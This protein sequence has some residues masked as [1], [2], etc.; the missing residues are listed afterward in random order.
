MQRHV[1]IVALLGLVILI[2]L[3][4]AVFVRRYTSLDSSLKGT[5]P[6]GTPAARIATE[7]RAKLVSTFL[8]PGATVQVRWVTF[9][10]EIV[11]GSWDATVEGVGAASA[12]LA[13][14]VNQFGTT[15]GVVGDSLVANDLF[16]Y[17]VEESSA[18][19]LKVT[20]IGPTL[21]SQ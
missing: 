1:K 2:V 20:V 3:V 10:P 5:L 15:P 21:R 14:I 11:G 4:A 12:V 19:H 8:K 7:S 18:G 13:Q 6:T 9:E 16:K 17:R